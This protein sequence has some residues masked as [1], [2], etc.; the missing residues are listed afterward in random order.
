MPT[1]PAIDGHAFRLEPGVKR[2]RQKRVAAYSLRSKADRRDRPS[3][4]CINAPW[5]YHGCCDADTLLACVSE[6]TVSIPV[7]VQNCCYAASAGPVRRA[8]IESMRTAG[9]RCP[10]SP[11]R[12]TI[13]KEVDRT[14]SHACSKWGLITSLQLGAAKQGGHYVRSHVS[15][16]TAAAKR[17]DQ[18][19]AAGARSVSDP[20]RHLLA[21]LNVTWPNQLHC[22][23][24]ATALQADVERLL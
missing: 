19:G 22:F 10:C 9:A 20:A 17:S 21:H 15:C 13:C 3:V 5:Q 2:S 6:R 24:Q 16:H 11:G 12:H 14:S 8:R 18:C 23:I 7:Y 1:T 4:L